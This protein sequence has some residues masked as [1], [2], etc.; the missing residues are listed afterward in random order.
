MRSPTGSCRS[1]ASQRSRR[2]SN[3]VHIDWQLLR[4]LLQ[5]NMIE[6]PEEIRKNLNKTFGIHLHVIFFDF[7]LQK[8]NDYL[9]KPK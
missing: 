3:S 2:G 1:A 7:Q 9:S 5:Q 8:C 6:I 4:G